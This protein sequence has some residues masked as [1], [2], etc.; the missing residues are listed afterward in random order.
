MQPKPIYNLE[1][2]EILKVAEN[3]LKDVPVEYIGDDEKTASNCQFELVEARSVFIQGNEVT[4]KNIGSVNMLLM[5]SY[6]T[7]LEIDWEQIFS[8]LETARIVR[9][10]PS[11]RR[12]Q[13]KLVQ[14]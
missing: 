3:I 7:H 1:N 12:S 2:M 11:V 5:I 6:L 13:F 4:T 14:N 8:E 9:M 10:I